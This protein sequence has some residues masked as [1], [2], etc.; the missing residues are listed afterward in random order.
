MCGIVGYANLRFNAQF[1]DFLLNAVN[2]LN[3][4]GPDGKD[5]WLD[6][7]KQVGLG[8]SRL[9]IVE[10]SKAG[11][12]PM[13]SFCGR[14]V[15][16]FNGEIYNHREIKNKL[17][18]LIPL[19]CWRGGSDTE[20]LVNAISAW[21]VSRTLSLCI[22]MFAFAVWDRQKKVLILSRDR[23]GEKPLYYT[24]QDGSFVFASEL[25]ALK[26]FRSLKCE[27]D[28]Q[29]L[30][31]FFNYSY[32]PAPLSIFKNVNK[33]E[34]AQVLE[35]HSERLEIVKWQYWDGKNKPIFTKDAAEPD[36]I[37]HALLGEVVTSQMVAD[38]P[39]GVFLSG[40]IDSSL[41]AAVM[42]SNSSA[43]IKS[44]TVGFDD[45]EYDESNQA[46]NVASILG[47]QHNELVLA[48]S[49][50]LNALP[51]MPT[52][53]D[54]PFADSSQIPTFLISRFASSDVKVCLSGDGGD[55]LFG[56]YNRHVFVNHYWK[57]LTKIPIGPRRFFAD[58]IERVPSENW[59]KY[60]RTL[61]QLFGWIN[62]WRLPSEKIEK[63]LIALQ[64]E[65]LEDLYFGLTRRSANAN[66]LLS[67]EGYKTEN[68]EILNSVSGARNFMNWDQADF[69][70]NDV[71]AKVDRASMGVSLE[72]RSPLLDYRIVEF[73]RTLDDQHLFGPTGGKQILRKVLK[74]Y[75]GGEYKEMPKMGFG[76]PIDK[77][78]R[79]ELRELTCDLLYKPMIER[80]GLFCHDSLLNVWEQHQ[81]GEKNWHHLLWNFVVFQ[82]WFQK[83][84]NELID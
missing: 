58:I 13:H 32:V 38:V 65:G 5:V 59:N 33:L 24:L 18:A 48:P 25:K 53:Y 55:E 49:D 51:L 56:G 40:G 46:K 81:R 64:A 37:L 79:D 76:V 77:W 47:T 72:V 30:E 50:L 29:A 22:G 68:R 1:P 62:L 15:I 16:T 45:K 9:A 67:P 60:S 69:L 84:N 14:Y 31:T 57:K 7:Q 70:P 21:G 17:N 4:R 61:N 39:V 10:L 66:F 83:Y 19:E 27:I 11:Q 74:R 20:V 26:N 78:F 82:L 54:E 71:L 34:P 44:Y 35:F 12:Q 52:L 2:S 28:R 63:I 43:S 23:M 6:A 75:L 42:Q 80:Q 3:H 41:I 73:S 8:H 36:T